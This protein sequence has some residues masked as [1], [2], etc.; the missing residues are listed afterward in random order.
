MSK[1]IFWSFAFFCLSMTSLSWL[2][3]FRLIRRGEIERHKRAMKTGGC[4]IVLFLLSYVAKLLF[5]GRED[6]DLWSSSALW[7]LRIHEVFMLVVL[8]GGGIAFTLASR[9]R[10]S[11][12]KAR[13]WHR[14][15][16]RA[17]VISSVFGL[18]TAFLVL[19]SMFQRATD[20]PREHEASVP[21][22]SEPSSYEVA[23][24][25]QK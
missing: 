17:A 10:G 11:T 18:A 25:R 20:T 19:L 1:L 15:L 14:R 12:D 16:G 24:G 4:F 22:A 7:T 23:S 21:V 8:L 5:L 9:F 6:L 13:S 2:V 3:G